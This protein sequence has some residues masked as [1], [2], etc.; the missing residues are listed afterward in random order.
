MDRKL[1]FT[2]M[3]KVG[4]CERVDHGDVRGLLLLLLG[5]LHDEAGDLIEEVLR[6]LVVVDE[7]LRRQVR[8]IADV[9]GEFE[10]GSPLRDVDIDDVIVLL[11]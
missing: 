11:A 2:K 1:K 9:V 5:V 10:R 4:T 6:Q 7:L 8:V 3:F